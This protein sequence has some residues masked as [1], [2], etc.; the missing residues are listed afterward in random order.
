MHA[1][2][3]ERRAR[4]ERE[5][6][7]HLDSMYAF[8]ARLTQDRHAAEDLVSDTVLRAFDHWEQYTLGTNAR[9]WLFTILYR[10]FI[11]GLRGEKRET[12]LPDPW[13]EGSHHEVAGQLDPEAAWFDS[14]IDEEVTQAIESLSERYREAVL[15]SDVHDFRYTEIAEILGI[16]EGTVKSRLFRGR[17]ILQRKLLGY[18]VEMGYVKPRAA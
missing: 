5:I 10:L 14:I 12:A 9:A 4:F 2:A 3:D 13:D 15:L 6:L 1:V 17:Q 8:A 7:T 11:S 16:A 18:A